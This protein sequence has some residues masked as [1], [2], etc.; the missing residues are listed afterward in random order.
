VSKIINCPA[1]GNEYESKSAPNHYKAALKAQRK[2]PE[3]HVEEMRDLKGRLGFTEDMAFRRL[4]RMNELERERLWLLKVVK[5]AYQKHH[6]DDDNIGWDELGTELHNAL[7]NSMGDD[8][9]QEWMES[10]RR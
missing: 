6:L 9:F 3:P 7:C 5:R 4:E 1:C 2:T 8:G 10:R